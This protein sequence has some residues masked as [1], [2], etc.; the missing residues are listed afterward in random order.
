[1]RLLVYEMWIENRVLFE[2][3]TE[4]MVAPY[5]NIANG[6]AQRRLLAARAVATR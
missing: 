2:L 4:D 3:V 6:A 5:A 1:V